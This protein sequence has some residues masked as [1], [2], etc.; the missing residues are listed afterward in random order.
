MMAKTKQTCFTCAHYGECAD[1]HYCGGTSWEQEEDEGDGDEEDGGYESPYDG[2]D[3]Y[4]QWE[5]DSEVWQGS[6]DRRW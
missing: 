3:P 2:P 5:H 6:A 4:E 1:L